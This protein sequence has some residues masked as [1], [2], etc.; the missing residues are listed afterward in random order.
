MKPKGLIIAVV[1][2]A[3]LGGAIWWSN[4]RQAGKASTPDTTLKVLSIPDADFQQIRIKNLTGDVIALRRENG[5]WALTEPKALPADQDAASSVVTALGA[6]N[7]DKLVE[8]KP[9]ELH[10][11]GL[12]IP[13]LEVTITRK[14]GKP[15]DL[16]VGGPTLD[17]AGYYAKL[18]NSAR[19]FTIAT[20]TKNTLEK[21]TDDLRDKRLLSFEPEAVT[22]IEA[23]NG[24]QAMEFSKN[25]QGEWQIVKPRPLRADSSQIASLVDKLRDAKMDVTEPSETAA[26]NFAAAAKV[27]SV[28]V[29]T[30]AGAQTLELRKSKENAFYARS[31]ALEGAYRTTPDVR[32]ALT[33]GLDEYRSKKIFD[34]GFS[35]PNKVELKSAAYEKSG[36]KWVSSGKPMDS[37]AVQTLIDKLRDLAATKFAEK[38]GGEPAFTAT[39]TS[40][41]GKRVERVAITKQGARY[42]AKR[43]G[44]PSIYELEAK[45]VEDLQ[46]AASGIK[47][48]PP[49]QPKK[50]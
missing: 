36:D 40:D 32:D 42:F 1:L 27:A 29:T 30:A 44:E 3:V 22:R 23:Q 35:D 5:K 45:T 43:E 17:G 48:A 15:D 21:R 9:A 16:L 26:K 33:K 49:E 6:L 13:T 37:A 39:V 31:S 12:D 10:S 19:V 2:L 18:A 20:A 47:E 8:E 25:G 28:V 4:K 46:S 38:G 34:F 14:D 41:G 50:K 11:F 24:T 7:A